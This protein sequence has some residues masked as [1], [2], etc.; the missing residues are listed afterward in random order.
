M[1]LSK[2][3]IASGLLPNRKL[4]LR[5]YSN[6]WCHRT[7]IVTDHY[8]TAKN[9]D[10]D[11]ALKTLRGTFVKR[12]EVVDSFR[13]HFNRFGEKLNFVLGEALKNRR[14]DVENS[15]KVPVYV[16]WNY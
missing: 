2:K 16:K 9:T 4:P 7:Y 8:G 5:S 13:K 10:R 15:A 3:H 11:E 1:D 6:I 14:V 12:W